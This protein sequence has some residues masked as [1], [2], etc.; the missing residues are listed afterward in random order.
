MNSAEPLNPKDKAMLQMVYDLMTQKGG[1]PTFTA[2]D[3]KAD[4]ELRIE[5]AQAA[6]VAV[7]PI[8]MLRPW[9]VFGFNDNDEVRLTLRGVAEC[10]GGMDDLDRLATFMKWIVDLEGKDTGS[11]DE[12]LI[13]RSTDFAE[14]CGL[15]LE[16][17]VDTDS[18]WA[19]T[20]PAD[21]ET[22][23]VPD[24][25]PESGESPSSPA[26]DAAAALPLP[27]DV[28]AARSQMTRL[29]LLAEMLPG[30]FNGATS[31]AERPWEWQYSIDRKRVRPYRR[32][33]GVDGLLDYV[34]GQEQRR[35]DAMANA[36]RTSPVARWQ[37]APS[38]S[39]WETTISEVEG[40]TGGAGREPDAPLTLLREEI[41]DASA[42]LLQDGHFDDAIFAALRRV[43]HEIQQRTGSSAIG[44][45]LVKHAFEGSP[46]RIKVSDRPRDAERMV[47]LF[48][49][50]IGLL[51]GDR[52]HKDK[53]L[54]PCTSRR[55][56]IRT[57][58]HASSLLDLLDRDVAR[59]PVVHGYE[60]QRNALTLWVER[61]G[62]DVEVWLDGNARLSK[63]SFRPGSLVVDAGGVPPGEHRVHL[64][65]GTRQ[66]PEHEVWLVTDPERTSWRRVIEV[67]VAL[68]SDAEAKH[69]IE[70]PGVRLSVRE[71]EVETEQIVPTMDVYEVGHYLEMGFDASHAPLGPTWARDPAT[72]TMTQLWGSSMVF[73][74]QPLAPAH[75]EKLMK[76]SL[77]PSAIRARRGDRVPIEVLGHFT[78]GTA[79]WTR[80]VEHPAVT[81]EDQRVIRYNDGVLTADTAGTT[82]LRCLH[83]GCFAVAAVEVASHPRGTTTAYL[84]GLPPV[85]GVAWTQS[86][87]VVSSRQNELWRVN[88]SGRYELLATVPRSDPDLGTD[89]IA[90]RADGELAVRLRGRR[91]IL[92]LHVG[93]DYASS[94]VLDPKVEGTPM[95]QA[96]DGDD[97]LVAMDSG[98]IV[99]VNP[100]G[101]TTT[102]GKVEGTPIGIARALGAYLVLA[103]FQLDP[104]TPPASRLWRILVD[105]PGEVIDLLEGHVATDMS[106]V[107]SDDDGIVLA[108]FH[109]GCLLRFVDDQFAPMVSGLSNPVQVTRSD[110][111]D[112]FVAELGAGAVCRVMG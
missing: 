48:G 36:A 14:Q 34:D 65:E 66:G 75:S 24:E 46:P 32:L 28:G 92:V 87:L 35:L 50:A 54:L 106:A 18:A 41:A 40:P 64:V 49:G 76:I 10:D 55:E 29:R 86:G 43:E 6:L 59:A 109:G 67:N 83:E 21:A 53:P 44:D 23:A 80:R 51:K 58:A 107:W 111:G 81:V 89:T 33:E 47:Q 19:G 88:R 17:P 20:R 101:N 9:H 1:W 63:T 97:V 68:Y 110:T 62:A 93:D 78:D 95:A 57:L 5:D 100:T 4:R 105:Q 72:G 37:V 27:P 30:F 22:S 108:Q 2:V 61:A 77:Q 112:Y 84:S 25:V 42:D 26:E 99:H 11:A 104:D 69:Q 103:T 74:G 85:G 102:I 73:N 60:H 39:V 79:T 31:S 45:G 70:V 82:R 13:A 71:G 7:P 16:A 15:S 90:S 52:S 91:E 94:H 56:C 98:E 3:L 96:W 12:Q 8:Y 38:R